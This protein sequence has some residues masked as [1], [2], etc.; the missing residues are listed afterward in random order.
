V[1]SPVD[2]VDV[3][4]QD[5]SDS[6][7][8]PAGDQHA[9]GGVMTTNWAVRGWAFFT[10]GRQGCRRTVVGVLAIVAPMALGAVVAV[11]T[12]G[13]TSQVQGP[14]GPSSVVL[15]ARA[16][17]DGQTTVK[18]PPSGSISAD[19]H[20]A[21]VVLD[22]RLER[23]DLVEVRAAATRAMP[24]VALEDETLRDLRELLVW[25]AVQAVGIAAV[26]AGVAGGLLPR[27]RWRHAVLAAFGG[28][29]TVAAP[30]RSPA[31]SSFPEFVRPSRSRRWEPIAGEWNDGDGVASARC[32]TQL[33]R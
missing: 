11:A 25:L 12:L 4:A 21:P 18:N 30:P 16:S 28:T 2:V 14:L 31:R 9:P 6:Q 17:S 3:D 13:F 5:G 22:V 7:D 32:C 20:R 19:T 10:C 27:R 26:V 8:T 1:A 23:I 24:L 33:R 29:A 15:E